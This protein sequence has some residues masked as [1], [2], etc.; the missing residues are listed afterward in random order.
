LIG[1]QHV[2]K[3]VDQRAVAFGG[4]AAGGF[5]ANL[6]QI[7]NVGRTPL[8]QKALHAD[9]FERGMPS[10]SPLWISS[11][12]ARIVQRDIGQREARDG[13][14]GGIAGVVEDVEQMMGHELQARTA[15]GV[16]GGLAQIGHVGA[17]F[18]SDDWERRIER[19]CAERPASRSRPEG[20]GAGTEAGGQV[21]EKDRVAPTAGFAVFRGL[22]QPVQARTGAPARPLSLGQRCSSGVMPAQRAISVSSASRRISIRR[23]ISNEMIVAERFAQPMNQS[24]G[25][26]AGN[27]DADWGNVSSSP[28][29][30]SGASP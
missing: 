7:Q 1:E 11:N 17:V 20:A 16:D 18:E 12:A 3:F 27:L 21:G 10:V 14:R 25:G 2:G 22:A 29:R 15:H 8:S 30:G 13:M 6:E 19:V 9:A 26:G 5:G 4:P 23:P 24:R 28:A